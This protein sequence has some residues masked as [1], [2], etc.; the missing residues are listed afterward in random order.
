MPFIVPNVQSLSSAQF[1]G[2][3]NVDETDFAILAAIGDG[4]GVITGCQVSQ[5]TGSNL[6]VNIA[7]GTLYVAGTKYTPGAVT[8][9]ALPAPPSGTLDRRDLVVYLVGTGYEI[10]QGPYPNAGQY[11]VKVAPGIA[12]GYYN[13]ATMCAVGEIYVPAGATTITT[14]ANITDKTAIIEAPLTISSSSPSSVSTLA[15]GSTGQV[16]DAGHTH[17]LSIVTAAGAVGTVLN[18]TLTQLGSTIS[19]TAGTWDVICTYNINNTTGSI[20]REATHAAITSGGSATIEA[21]STLLAG[22]GQTSAIGGT[23]NSTVTA[24]GTVVVTST[25][26]LEMEF[27]SSQADVNLVSVNWLA[28]QSA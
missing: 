17:N 9:Q 23:Q 8:A 18:G 27:A 6:L 28:I 25:T 24:V 19:L 1:P 26:T 7:A 12:S 4:T 3:A 10:L 14:A 15:A 13:A 16:S 20:S 11:P 5:N 2:M 21:N 22:G